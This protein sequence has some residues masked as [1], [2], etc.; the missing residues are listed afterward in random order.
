MAQDLRELGAGERMRL[1]GVTIGPAKYSCR[2]VPQIP[3]QAGSMSTSPGCGSPGG[4]TSYYPNVTGRMKP[5]RLH[6]GTSS[7]RAVP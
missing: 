7:L 5:S 1:A 4:S 2:S 3:H 6:D